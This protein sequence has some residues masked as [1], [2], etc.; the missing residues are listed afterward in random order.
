[1]NPEKNRLGA[2]LIFATHDTNLLDLEIIRRDQIWFAEKDKVESADI[3]SLV[4][5]KDENGKKFVMTVTSSA[6]TFAD[7]MAPYHS[8]ENSV[9][10]GIFQKRRDCPDQART[11]RGQD[12]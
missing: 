6:I 11:S 3:Y 8:S 10:L 12:F 5:F 7:A 4:E 1:M 9:Q 2:Q